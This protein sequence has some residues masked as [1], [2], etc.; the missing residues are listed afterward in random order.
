MDYQHQLQ[1]NNI[2]NI[3]EFRFCTIQSLMNTS[4]EASLQRYDN[5]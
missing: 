3:L 4:D 5:S 2:G 1:E